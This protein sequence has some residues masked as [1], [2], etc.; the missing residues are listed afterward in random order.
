MKNDIREER[1]SKL[2]EISAIKKNR[3]LKLGIIATVE[4]MIKFLKSKKIKY[5][6]NYGIFE[7][8]IK[9]YTFFIQIDDAYIIS[10]CWTN[11]SSDRNYGRFFD[12][13]EYNISIEKFI[14]NFDNIIKDVNKLYKLKEK[15]D[16]NINGIKELIMSSDIENVVISDECFAD[17]EFENLIFTSN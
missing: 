16:K 17:M 13:C 10:S 12:L 11:I 9:Y 8:K 15:V 4:M 5:F 7:I 2:N 1:I 14:M 6:L 3:I